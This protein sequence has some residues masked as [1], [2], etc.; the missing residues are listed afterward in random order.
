MIRTRI[1]A[2]LVL[3]MAAAMLPGVTRTAEASDPV[4]FRVTITNASDPE[5]ILSPGVWL[6][7]DEPG[8][9]WARDA[10]ASLAIERIAEIGNP[11]EA[12]SALGA[13]TIGAAPAA[14]STVVF[15]V[16]AQPGDLLSTIQML[17][18]TNDGFVGLQSIALFDGDEPMSQT[19][20]LVAYE[21][22]TEEN[23]GLFT[24]FAGGQPDESRGA[25][26][27]DNG[28]ATSEPI[29]LL[30]LVDGTQATATIEVVQQRAMPRMAN[31]GNAG[32]TTSDGG[33]ATWQ[34]AILAGVVGLTVAGAAYARRRVA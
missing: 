31:T 9:L 2:I 11:A 3:A 21:A 30:D 28:V 18:A 27:V 15:E 12:V 6:L 7:H 13:T 14:G 32:L 24:G 29:R 4:T 34:W 16:I 20:E 1:A 33:P 23:T 17:V 10:M 8:E 5:Q 19:I 26:N 25:D 22:G